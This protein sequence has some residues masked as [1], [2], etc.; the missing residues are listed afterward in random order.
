MTTEYTIGEVDDDRLERIVAYLAEH[1]IEKAK[2]RGEID[3][4]A[5]VKTLKLFDGKTTIAIA[6]E[7]T[8]R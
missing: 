7:T 8:S 1:E 5:K 4:V 3:P 2:E 6:I